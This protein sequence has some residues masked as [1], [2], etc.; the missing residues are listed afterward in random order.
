MKKPPK[1]S[2]L[3]YCAGCGKKIVKSEPRKR[4][5]EGAVDI[6]FGFIMSDTGD[7]KLPFKEKKKWGRM[8]LTCFSSAIGTTDIL[9]FHLDQQE[10][11]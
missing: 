2:Y 6:R 7:E 10:R 3:E 1:P 8:H 5:G 4:R 9:E 11:P